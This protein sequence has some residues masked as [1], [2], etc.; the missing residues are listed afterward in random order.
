M[1]M[2]DRTVDDK[3]SRFEV[4]WKSPDVVGFGRWV[5]PAVGVLGALILSGY[6]LTATPV[7]TT[8][9][10][11]VVRE[12]APPTPAPVSA[13]SALSSNPA[14][15]SH[16]GPASDESMRTSTLDMLKAVFGAVIAFAWAMIGG[17]LG[18]R[19]KG[20]GPRSRDPYEECR[21][22]PRCPY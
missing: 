11:L 3:E 5:N 13:L 8:P 14:I 1:T 6:L 18:V 17:W 15:V 19:R 2:F 12:M 22:A 9:A 7:A 10:P 20:A 4:D 16:F 21:Q